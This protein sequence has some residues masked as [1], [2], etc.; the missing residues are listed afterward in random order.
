MNIPELEKLLNTFYQISGIEVALFD[1]KYHSI[2]SIKNST[3]NFCKVIHRLPKCMD[4]C[5]ESDLQHLKQLSISPKPIT[6]TCPFGFYTAF[7]PIMENNEPVAYLTLAPAICQDLP[8]CSDDE[9]IQKTKL[10]EQSINEKVL[11]KSL[12]AIPRYS[13]EKLE[14]FT[15]ILIV[16]A[17]V[18]ESRQLISTQEQ[19]I[20]FLIKN[21]VDQHLQSKITLADLS[22]HLHCSTVTLTEHFKKDYGISIMQYVLNQR[23]LLAEKLLSEGVHTINTVSLLCGFPDVEYFSRTFKKYHNVSP[24]KWNCGSKK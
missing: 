14:A 20:S 22:W 16:L 23:M 5:T 2:I 24:S 18:I 9:L 10:H 15:E 1:S 19:S 8:N 17:Q 12:T 13:K 6:Y 3:D 7:V 4:I 11:R 21:Y